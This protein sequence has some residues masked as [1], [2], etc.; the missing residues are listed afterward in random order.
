ML[1]RRRQPPRPIEHRSESWSGG[2]A[3]LQVVSTV[4]ARADC[5]THAGHSRSGSRSPSALRRAAI[6]RFDNGAQKV[7]L[8]WP[9]SPTTPTREPCWISIRDDGRPTSAR[10]A[11]CSCPVGNAAPDPNGLRP[12]GTFMRYAFVRS[13]RKLFC[14]AF[15]PFKP[16][17]GWGTRLGRGV[18]ADA[19]LGDKRFQLFALH[20]D[21][22]VAALE[23][24]CC[25]RSGKN[26]L[27]KLV[28]RGGVLEVE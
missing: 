27:L 23:Q 14:S 28:K 3:V 12:A 9:L 18:G 17:R 8:P 19:I 4:C 15:E 6:Q 16:A 1:R 11:V 22:R 25:S 7:V 20:A 13:S 2:G 5:Y 24:Y 26:V 21:G 10:I